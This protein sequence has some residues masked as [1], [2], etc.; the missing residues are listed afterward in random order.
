MAGVEGYLHDL[1]SNTYG[2][3]LEGVWCGGVVL[4]SDMDAS[5]A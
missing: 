3:T 2:L 4:M 1:H 5:S